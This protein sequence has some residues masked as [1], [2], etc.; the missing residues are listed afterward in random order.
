VQGNE[1][2]VVV[3]MQDVHAEFDAIRTKY[4]IGKW[5]AKPVTR[6]YAFELPDV[7]AETEYLKVL[8]SYSGNF[9]ARSSGVSSIKP[10]H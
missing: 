7:P 3:T 4:S 9:H 5:L 6:K 1:T 8:Y 2:D 10:A